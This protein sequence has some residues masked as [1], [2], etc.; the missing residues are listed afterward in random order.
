VPGFT[1]LS[2]NLYVAD[3]EP[4]ARAWMQ[5]VTW[6]QVRA[7]MALV[8]APPAAVAAIRHDPAGTSPGNVA[9]QAYTPG[10]IRLQTTATRPA[11]LVVAETLAP[12]WRATLDGQPVPIWRANYLSQGVVVPAGAHTVELHYQPD[13]VLVG[14]GISGVALLVYFGSAILASRFLRR[15]VSRRA[16]K[17]WKPKS[18]REGGI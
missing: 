1:Y 6:P 11:L 15:I 9:V 5:Q 2:D 7:Y 16:S 17:T 12:G 3:G 14:A 8:E 4:A 10:A 13:S 18:T